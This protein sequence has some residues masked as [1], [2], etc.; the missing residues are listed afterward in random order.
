M[1]NF[2][3]VYKLDFPQFQKEI[4]IQKKRGTAIYVLKRGKRSKN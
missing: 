3:I 4:Y 1:F 2:I